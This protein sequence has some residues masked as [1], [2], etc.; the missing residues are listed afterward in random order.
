MPVCKD[1]SRVGLADS[2]QMDGFHGVYAGLSKM[3]QQAKEQMKI[4][5]GQVVFSGSGGEVPPALT[6]SAY[7]RRM[8]LHTASTLDLPVRYTKAYKFL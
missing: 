4:G 7:Y 6:S 8:R 2:P 1:L 5:A 3:K